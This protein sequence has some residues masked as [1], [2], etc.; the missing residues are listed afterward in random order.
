MRLSDAKAKGEI[1]VNDNPAMVHEGRGAYMIGSFH[2]VY[3]AIDQRL[4]VGSEKQTQPWH[5][6]MVRIFP[7]YVHTQEY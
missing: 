2:D 6:D 1:Y 7:N 4:T 3:P 5:A